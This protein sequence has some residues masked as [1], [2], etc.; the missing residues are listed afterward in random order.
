MLMNENIGNVKIL[1]KHCAKVDLTNN[2]SK[3]PLH[4]ASC[5]IKN[6][7]ILKLLINNSANINY[8]DHDDNSPLC[9]AT[10]LGNNTAVELLLNLGADDEIKSELIQNL[11]RESQKNPKIL[12]SNRVVQKYTIKLNKLHLIKNEICVAWRSLISS[13]VED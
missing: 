6:V 11:N 10:F 13:H 1:L 5:K 4:I 12:E 3:T 7:D 8:R 2:S 9:F